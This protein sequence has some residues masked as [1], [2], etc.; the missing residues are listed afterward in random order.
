MKLQVKELLEAVA[1][2]DSFLS[3]YMENVSANDFRDAIEQLSFIE[4]KKSNESDKKLQK[5]AT[6]LTFI[7]AALKY[8]EPTLSQGIEEILKECDIDLT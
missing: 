3:T 5:L 7:R 1:R 2:E 8:K 6:T 4:S